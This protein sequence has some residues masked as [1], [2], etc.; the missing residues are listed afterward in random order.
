MKICVKSDCVSAVPAENPSKPAEILSSSGK[1]LRKSILEV[2]SGIGFVS[3]AGTAD[4]VS[5]IY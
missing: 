1:D 2:G 5:L 4:C 3:P